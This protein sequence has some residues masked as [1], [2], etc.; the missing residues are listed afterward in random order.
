MAAQPNAAPVIIKR[1]KKVTGDG[2]HGGAWKVAYADFVTA[3]MAFFMLMWLLNATSEKQRKG[4]ADYFAPTVPIHRMSDGS[5][6][7]FGGDSLFSEDSQK[8]D[9]TGGSTAYTTESR[10][11]RG[12]TGLET[13]A[14]QA[15]ED[16]DFKAL[17][18]A[19]TGRSGESMVSEEALRHI[20]TRVTDEGLIIELFAR[21]E[22]ALFEAGSSE[23]TQLMRELVAMIA[24]VSSLV[25]NGI[26]IDGHVPSNPVVLA[27]NPVWDVSTDRAQRIRLLMEAG[28]TVAARLKRVTGHADRAP[29]TDN[30][31]APRNE[32]V[33]ITLLRTQRR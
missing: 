29:A 2:H 28:G 14:E 3:M 22:A 13:S 27:R 32:R 7:P 10:Q 15:A 21:P 19:M 5:D 25:G 9:G 18:E 31:M 1:K 6:N 16:E 12:E 20:V 17:E 4:L 33:E 11:S 23:P 24:R 26:A 8:N 30:T